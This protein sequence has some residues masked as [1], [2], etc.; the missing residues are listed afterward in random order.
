MHSSMA[1]CGTNRGAGGYNRMASFTTA[2]RVTLTR[3]RSNRI[4]IESHN[5]DDS[6]QF[7]SVTCTTRR[8]I[9]KELIVGREAISGGF[10]AANDNERLHP[11]PDGEYRAVFIRQSSQSSNQWFLAGGELPEVADQRPCAGDYRRAKELETIPRSSIIDGIEAGRYCNE[12]GKR[13]V[14]STS[15]GVALGKVAAWP[16]DISTGIFKGVVTLNPWS[17]RPMKRNLSGKNFSGSGHTCGLRCIF[18]ALAY[19]M[20]PFGMFES[21]TYLPAQLGGRSARILSLVEKQSLAVSQLLMITDGCI[22]IRTV[23]I[24]PYLS[25]SAPK[26]RISGSLPEVSCRRWPISGHAPGTTGGNG[27]FDELLLLFLP[28][29]KVQSNAK[30]NIPAMAKELETTS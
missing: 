24:G 18:H 12:D 30:M 6:I 7:E 29:H 5:R 13:G 4:D 27:A 10:P 20:V 21:V 28:R 23:N 15:N 16:S 26:V 1:L 14:T 25:A 22:P 17:K 2:W 9:S 11:D 8:A 19:K 3:I